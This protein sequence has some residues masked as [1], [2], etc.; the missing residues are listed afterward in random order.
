M[1]YP[2]QVICRYA[3][4][5]GLLFGVACNSTTSSKGMPKAASASSQALD[6]HRPSQTSPPD[7]LKG[8]KVASPDPREARLAAGT[9]NNRHTNSQTHNSQF[10]A[11]ER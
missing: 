5:V 9:C 4:L 10:S 11:I 3:I 6:Q 8:L 7:A 1:R 2:E